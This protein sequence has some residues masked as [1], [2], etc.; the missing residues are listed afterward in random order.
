[1]VD[2]CILKGNGTPHQDR[3]LRALEGLWVNVD[4]YLD[5]TTPSAVLVGFDGAV[6]LPGMLQLSQ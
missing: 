6:M 1:M 3:S 5:G 2:V 4:F